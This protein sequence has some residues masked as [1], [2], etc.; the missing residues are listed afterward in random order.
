VQKGKNANSKKMV[1]Y[2]FLVIPKGKK[3]VVEMVGRWGRVA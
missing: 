2:M 3:K 1:I